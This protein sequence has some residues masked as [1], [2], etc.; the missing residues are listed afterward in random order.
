MFTVIVTIDIRPNRRG[1]F[2]AG[3]QANAAASR[4]EPGCLR[5]DV[6][7]VS[8][9]PN[10]YVLYEIYTDA[11]AFYGAHRAAPH[12]AAWLRVVETCVLDKTNTY[13]EPL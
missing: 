9:T 4:E 1:E 6:N 7:R 12:Y 13:A 3:I 5:F 2:E 8:D 10:R 11:D